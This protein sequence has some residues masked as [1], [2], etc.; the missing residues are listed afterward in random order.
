MQLLSFVYKQFFNLKY[1]FTVC[2]PKTAPTYFLWNL[3]YLKHLSVY[4]IA[5]LII[6]MYHPQQYFLWL[7]VSIN[8]L[9]QIKMVSQF[10]EIASIWSTLYICISIM[11]YKRKMTSQDSNFAILSYIYLIAFLKNVVLGFNIRNMSGH[12][13]MSQF[14]PVHPVWQWHLYPPWRSWQEWAFT[15]GLPLH[16]SESSWQWA[17]PQ[18]GGHRHL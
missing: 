10:W 6:I 7:P 4:L 15:Q 13:L 18:P 16:S 3:L 11:K 14:F 8:W 2:R 1:S 12:V 9:P 17:P 5:S